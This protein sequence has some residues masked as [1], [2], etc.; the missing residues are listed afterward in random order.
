MLLVIKHV[1]KGRIGNETLMHLNV[2]FR[3][4]AKTLMPYP[5]HS[6]SDSPPIHMYF[7][8]G[9]LD[10]IMMNFTSVGGMG[11]VFNLTV[12]LASKVIIRWFGQ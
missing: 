6:I 1:S 3:L 11:T 12:Q 2:F 5:H 9:Y 8:C 10:P 7:L 4:Q